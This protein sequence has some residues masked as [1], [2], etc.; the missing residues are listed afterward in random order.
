MTSRGH[1]GSAGWMSSGPHGFLLCL[2]WGGDVV[3]SRCLGGKLGP[4]KL[5]FGGG[6][7]A[8]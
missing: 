7:L 6:R 3:D 8:N 4:I 5:A 1:E 2:L